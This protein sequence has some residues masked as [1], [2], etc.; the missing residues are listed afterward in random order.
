M[1][2][3]VG[4][5]I[6]TCILYGWKFWWI[7][8]FE[9]NLP[10]FHLPKNF[11]VWCHPYCKTIAFTCTRSA[12]RRGSLIVG[13]S[14]PLK[15]TCKNITSPKSFVHR[16]WGKSWFVFQHEVGNP[17]DVYAV[18]V[19]NNA[20]KTVQIKHNNDLSTFQM[21]FITSFVLTERRY[22]LTYVHTYYAGASK[23]WCVV[24][25]CSWSTSPAAVS[26]LVSCV[27]TC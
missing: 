5:Y 6:H 15:A 18:A 17:N 3:Y 13:W 19:K 20:M 10:K 25:T 11:T 1:H 2:M 8:N 14:S 22:V 12:A 24:T 26:W 16:R 23:P 21:H 7:G 9:S 4:T 27:V